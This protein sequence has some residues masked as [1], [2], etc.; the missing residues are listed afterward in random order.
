M[1]KLVETTYGEA[2]F[3]LAIQESKIDEL[4]EEAQVVIDVFK[5]NQDLVKILRSPKV[6]KGDKEEL[7]KNVFD[8]FVSKDITGLLTVMVSKDRQDKIVSTLQY[9]IKR[10]YEY[11][12]GVAFVTTARPLTDDQKLSVVS[13]LLATTDY[14]DFKINYDIDE[15][16]IA[17][18]VIRI[19]DRV[20]DSSVKH[21]IDELA[22]N[23][24][25]IQL[26]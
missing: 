25:N 1:A 4:C 6:E 3:E 7:I 18:M 22:R 5:D 13:R 15:S 10:V 26:A 21:K 11:K 2:L 8:K 17:G 19:G 12:I 16:L 14:V 24:K 9:F 23:L 20:V